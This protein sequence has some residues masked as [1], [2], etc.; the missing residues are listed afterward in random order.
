MGSASA[1]P[2]HP[3]GFRRILPRV[4]ANCAHREPQLTPLGQRSVSRARWGLL[5]LSR[6]CR[7]QTASS[8]AWASTRTRWVQQYAR[9]AGLV[10]IRTKRAC[11]NVLR[12]MSVAMVMLLAEPPSA[13]PAMQV[14][15]SP[16]QTRHR[17]QFAPRES[18]SPSQLRASASS[19]P[20]ADTDRPRAIQ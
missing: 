10:A 17:V 20:W 8:A 15:S 6:A 3:A 12:A 18:I 11:R 7:R 1:S 5:I 2:A 4:H 19:A 14:T 13:R 16:C 9:S